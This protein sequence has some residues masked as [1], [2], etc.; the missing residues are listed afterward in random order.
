MPFFFENEQEE[1]ITVNGDCYRAMLKE[2]L[3]T[4]IEEEDIGNIW[5]QHDGATYH[6]AEDIFDVLWPVFEDRIVSR[7][8]DVVWLPRSCDLIPLD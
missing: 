7:R 6:T 2:F 1:A 3:L 5:F 4:R 8:A